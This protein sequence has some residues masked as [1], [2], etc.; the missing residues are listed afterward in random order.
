MRG[1]RVKWVKEAKRLVNEKGYN[2]GG[3]VRGSRY[4]VLKRQ[5]CEVGIERECCEK[6]R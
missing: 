3:R 1:A 2:G 6:V 4:G 5:K